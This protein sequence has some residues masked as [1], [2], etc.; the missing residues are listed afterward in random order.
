V[1]AYY[2]QYAELLKELTE[3]Q[4]HKPRPLAKLYG[5]N[6][7]TPQQRIAWEE[8]VKTYN[9]KVSKIRKQLPELLRKSNEEFYARQKNG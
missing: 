8:S 6:G 1:S 9:R 5:L 2:E 3:L 4:I 7:P